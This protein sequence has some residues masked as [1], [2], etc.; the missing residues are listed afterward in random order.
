MALF[1]RITGADRRFARR[2]ATVAK[3]PQGDEWNCASRERGRAVVPSFVIILAV[4]SR[5][6]IWA[7]FWIAASAQSPPLP[8]MD[9]ALKPLARAVFVRLGLNDRAQVTLRNMSSLSASEAN[10]ARASLDI[11]L[12]KNVRNPVNV[13][14]QLTISENLQGYLLI[15]EM[16]GVVEMAAFRGAAAATEP[17]TLVAINRKL[18][19]QQESAIL[20]VYL[21]ADQMLVLDVEGLA[22]YHL[23][24]GKWTANGVALLANSPARD[25]RGQ[26][27]ISGSNVTAQLPGQTCRGEWKPELH[28]ECDESA[29]QL[30]SGKNTLAGADWPEHYTHVQIGE[31]HILAETDGRARL[32]DGTHKLLNEMDGWGSDVVPVPEACGPARILSTSTADRSGMDSITAYGI[33]NGTPVRL[34]DPMIFNGPVTALWPEPTGALAI[35]RNSSTRRYE[36]YSLTLDCSR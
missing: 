20:D 36:A 28:L 8:S 19:W 7:C 3:R 16:E 9:E 23:Q 1:T 29:A 30:V 15:A 21:D 2:L 22:R 4:V 5:C 11:A 13:P 27:E 6:L 12:R 10:R 14:V 17:R 24:N 35:A 34:S 18:V 31:L 32:Y 33:S 26:L 25:P